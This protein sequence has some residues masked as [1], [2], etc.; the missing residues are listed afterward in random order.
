MKIL[1][2]KK[3]LFFTFIFSMVL[4]NPAQAVITFGIPDCGQWVNNKTETRKTWLLGYMSG[5]SVMHELNKNRDDPLKKIN[6]AQQIYLWMDN[7]C[8]KNPLKDVSDGGAA[9]FIELMGK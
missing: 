8:Q 5:L 2:F 3:N 4:L 9:L 7:Y 1:N 6:S